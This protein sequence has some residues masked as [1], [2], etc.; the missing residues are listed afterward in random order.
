MK[1]TGHFWY[2]KEKVRAKKESGRNHLL[3]FCIVDGKTSEYNELT[4][5]KEPFGSWDDYAY[6]G[7][8]EY[9]HSVPA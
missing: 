5:K 9:S 6:I 7:Y 4:D 3:T 2:S 1:I 8:G